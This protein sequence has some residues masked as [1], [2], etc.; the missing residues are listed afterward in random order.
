MAM[1]V[2]NGPFLPGEE[3]RGLG[4]NEG[5]EV[6]KDEA[7]VVEGEEGAREARLCEEVET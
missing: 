1:E 3:T 7:G 6:D 2:E 5:R 4:E